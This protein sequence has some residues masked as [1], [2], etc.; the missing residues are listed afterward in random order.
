VTDENIPVTVPAGAAASDDGPV[1]YL[2]IDHAPQHG[3][4]EINTA[5]TP[6]DTSDDYLI[7]TPD[8]DYSGTDTF[9]YRVMDIWGASD[10]GTVDVTINNV[11]QPP[12]DNG[13]A[14]PFTTVNTAKAL[15]VLGQFSNPGG[16]SLSVSA[17]D[18]ASV[19]G[20]TVTHTSTTV[21]YTPDTDYAG[22]D[23]FTYT[24]AN[25]TGS[26]IGKSNFLVYEAGQWASAVLGQSAG[27]D[28]VANATGEPDDANWASDDPDASLDF[29]TV[30]FA[31][32]APATGI[33]IHVPS[34]GFISSVELLKDDG[35]GYVPLWSGADPTAASDFVLNFAETGYN[36]LGARITVNA[37]G[38]VD[39]V[40]ILTGGTETSLTL[41]SRGFDGGDTYTDTT[42]D[43]SG[44]AVLVKTWV[45]G[46]LVSTVEY[47]YSSGVL[48]GVTTTDGDGNQTNCTYDNNGN[49]LTETAA[50]GTSGAAT[51]TY[52]YDSH[53]RPTSFTDPKG[54]VTTWDYSVANQV[55]MTDP[56]G[57]SEVKVYNTDGT[58]ASI[59]S[60]NNKLITYGYTDG[61][62]TGE[63]WYDGPADT[64]TVL[65]TFAWT[66]NPD[67]TI[68]TAA[69]SEGTY[70]FTYNTAGQVTHVGEV[71]GVWLTFGYDG[72]GHRN[73]VKDSFG[74]EED[75]LY[76]ARG[77]L[78][79]RILTQGT[80]VLRIDQTFDQNGRVLTQTRYS[81]AV[82]TTLVGTT[83]YTHDTLGNVASIVHKDGESTPVTLSEFGYTYDPAGQLAS[84]TDLQTG[85]SGT[86]W[87]NYYG[88][89]HQ[90]Q[91]T[92]DGTN[93]Y[94][95]DLG[96]NRDTGYT[97]V[98]N[99]DAVHYT[100]EIA[101][102]GTWNYVY[103]NNGNM[104]ERDHS[105]TAEKW[106]YKYDNANHLIQAKHTN[107]SAVVDM[108]ADYSYDVFRNR[109][110][111]T[112]DDDGAGPDPA[113]VQRYVLDGWN[114][115]KGTPAGNENYDV[116]A[117]LD[118]ALSLTTRYLR[119]DK[120]DELIG[121]VDGSNPY[122]VL[123][124]HLG[125]IRDVIDGGGA[126]ADSLKYDSF[127]NIDTGT[128]TNDA[129]RGRYTWTG[130]ELDLETQLQYNRGRYYDA[131]TG[132]WISQDP[133]GFDAGDSNL[134]RYLNNAPTGG[135]DP[136]GLQELDR[137]GFLRGNAVKRIGDETTY[138][139]KSSEFAIKGGPGS[140]YKVFVY[141]GSNAG[142]KRKD[143][144]TIT[145]AAQITVQ[146][147]QNEHL[148]PPT[149]DFK[150]N[151][152]GIVLLQLG[153]TTV[154]DSYDV[155][156]GK[157]GKAVLTGKTIP[158][159]L[160]GGDQVLQK[161]GTI[162]LDANPKSVWFS[163]LCDFEAYDTAFSVFDRPGPSEKDEAAAR[164]VLLKNGAKLIVHRYS[165]YF[166]GDRLDE[167]F[168][169]LTWMKY[170]YYDNTA[171]RWNSFYAVDKEQSR[172]LDPPERFSG[173]EFSYGVNKSGELKRKVP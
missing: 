114:P 130:R 12:V 79:R 3:T 105:G 156:T 88:Y 93:S 127:G 145:K 136:S 50:Y 67:G 19:N 37:G 17:A 117:D 90:G 134:Y 142:F 116:W 153:D 1:I 148:G 121:R 82:G 98:P 31:T 106:E 154:Y 171:E 24:V 62:L 53:N 18:A 144:N 59:L 132:R 41:S 139:Y 160:A 36:V 149:N 29:I 65:E 73:L 85:I 96:G 10:T 74:G 55:T 161:L 32:A 126:L 30:T 108:Q 4:V 11:P 92:A 52:T 68:Q 83:T 110:Q 20:G 14:L 152:P 43:S 54:N 128:E 89:D 137:A 28:A 34:A 162:Y 102:D 60:R 6:D 168:F 103:D 8:Q 80:N 57:N 47:T 87:T 163:D 107:T 125:S 76:D 169:K 131:T 155:K 151:G 164:E 172:P 13:A 173:R 26:T 167:A 119:G 64:D 63:T 109:I 72:A 157:V 69:N 46:V 27:A 84:E 33:L 135:T 113:V 38:S 138:I 81:D 158:V 122:W 21:T 166:F 147:S 86:S 150:K 23:F 39:A 56:F 124:D 143:G 42:Y 101:S 5:S 66:Y 75:S 115:A 146:I 165:T 71:F 25:S 40:R 22:P 78:I 45:Q 2:Q 15:S 118:G 123:T 140:N 120:V 112:V 141:F 51:T 49:K 9:T 77:N 99:P 129:Y 58:L 159:E 44:N 61:K 97:Y 170:V 48:S 94:N 111:K 70:T 16:G 133:L 104:T 35:S 7:Y 100:N 95:Y 91:L